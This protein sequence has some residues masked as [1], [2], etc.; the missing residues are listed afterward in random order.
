MTPVPPSQATS[1]SRIRRFP[2][3]AWSTLIVVYLADGMVEGVRAT[4]T[5][6]AYL[7]LIVRIWLRMVRRVAW[8]T[9]S[10]VERKPD[11]KALKT[12]HIRIVHTLAFP[13]PSTKSVN[14]FALAFWV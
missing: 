12:G 10:S 5:C 14:L 7:H 8:W 3:R 2:Y 11:M 13:K 1:K 4:A 9:S 6:H